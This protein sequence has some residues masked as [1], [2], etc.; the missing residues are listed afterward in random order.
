MVTACP[1]GGLG[2]DGS[3]FGLIE[4]GRSTAGARGAL[5][6]FTSVAGGG[7]GFFGAFGFGGG[8]TRIG[9]GGGDGSRPSRIDHG[10]DGS[11]KD[12]NLRFWISRV[13]HLVTRFTVLS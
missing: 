1:F 7:G 2:A 13:S 11:E 4:E 3:A 8:R 12:L 5:G 6:G 10:Q 9:F